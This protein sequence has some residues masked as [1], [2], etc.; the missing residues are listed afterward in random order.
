MINSMLVLKEKQVIDFLGN[1]TFINVD[2]SNNLNSE[3]NTKKKIH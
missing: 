2:Q 1:L 3:G